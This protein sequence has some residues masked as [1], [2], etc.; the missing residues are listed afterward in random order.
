MRRH[1]RG[2]DDAIKGWWGKNVPV[3][4][5]R[6]YTVGCASASAGGTS[7]CA[8][9]SVSAFFEKDGPLHER[10]ATLDTAHT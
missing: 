7:L 3:L 4:D 8:C 5:V 6:T 1:R 9:R 2:V 10:F